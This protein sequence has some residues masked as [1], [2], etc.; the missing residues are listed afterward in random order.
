[1]RLFFRIY[2]VRAGGESMKNNRKSEVHDRKRLR[3]N[4]D[5]KIRKIAGE[6]ILIATGEAAGK[7][8]GLV[9]FNETACEIW[10]L[11]EQEKTEEEICNGLAKAYGITAECCK[12]DVRAFLRTAIEKH[13]ILEC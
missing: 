6:T 8:H 12:E 1:M 4:A 7:F 10:D 9:S 2:I 3:K 11:L 5:F 13:L